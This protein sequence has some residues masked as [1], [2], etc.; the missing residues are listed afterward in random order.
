M[1]RSSMIVIVLVVVAAACGGADEPSPGTPAPAT[2]AASGATQPPATDPPATDPPATGA[3]ATDPPATD[4]PATTAAPATTAPTTAAPAGPPAVWV[5]NT[6]EGKV[7]KV[8]PANGAILLDVEVGMGAAGVAVGAGSAWVGIG[9]AEELVRVDAETGEIQARIGITGGAGAV[10]FSDG[11]V[12]TSSFSGETVFEIDPATNSVVEEHAGF[13]GP[14]GLAPGSLWVTTWVGRELIR[15]PTDD[16]AILVQALGG[17]G[18]SPAVGGGYVA[19]TLFEE[20]SLEVFEFDGETLGPPTSYDVGDNANVVDYGFGAFWVTNSFTGE[21]W[22]VDPVA[23]TA[24]AVTVIPIATGIRAG[25]DMIY[26]TAYHAGTVYQF[27]PDNS[28]AMADLVNVGSN[29]FEL[30]YGSAG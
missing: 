14:T 4:P 3:P 2:T 8:D 13:L 24:E 1:R 11:R 30:T 20:G 27:P 19:A 15:I 12:W 10:A 28:G 5:T 6:V 25:D 16:S 17:A 29:A 21:I 26:V 7:F 18:S 23:G 22:R 9:P